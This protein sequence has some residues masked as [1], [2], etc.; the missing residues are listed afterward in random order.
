MSW[1]QGMWIVP[2]AGRKMYLGG[3]AAGV[4]TRSRVRLCV[5]VCVCVRARARVSVRVC[6]CV[7]VS[8]AAVGE[9][10]DVVRV[11]EV[12]L[13]HQPGRRHVVALQNRD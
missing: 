4:A 6:V 5:C 3:G 1:M 11:V 8:L 13:E 10:G 7:R 12:V 9:L 2:S